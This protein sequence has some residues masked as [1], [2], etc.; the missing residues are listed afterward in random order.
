MIG[1]YAFTQF[2]IAIFATPHPLHNIF[3]LLSMPG[4]FTPLVLAFAWRGIAPHNLIVISYLLGLVV[5]V[6]V[7]LG[8][9]ELFPQ[10]GLWQLVS[11]YPGLVQRLLIAGWLPWFVAAGI[12]LMRQ[13]RSMDCNP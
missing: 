7:V 3:G 8:L 4:Y 6:A 5:L 13:Q 1:Y 11:P 2:G 9:S 10:L 12:L